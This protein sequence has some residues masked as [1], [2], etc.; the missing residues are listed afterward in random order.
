[1]DF[2]GF[3]VTEKVTENVHLTQWTFGIPEKLIEKRFRTRA[4]V[5]SDRL[6][7]HEMF[8]DQHD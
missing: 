3:G 1:M 2:E 7:F 4:S 6:T 8:A 5:T